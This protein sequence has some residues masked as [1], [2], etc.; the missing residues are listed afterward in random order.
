MV[1]GMHVAAI[2]LSGCS[3]ASDASDTSVNT[4]TVPRPGSAKITTFEAPSSVACSGHPS[5]TFSVQYET[6]GA[7]YQQLI[8]DGRA[9][10]P[11]EAPSGAMAAPVHCD[12]LQHT[13][14]L[15]A[16]DGKGRLTSQAKYLATDVMGTG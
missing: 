11:S 6:T 15:A 2:A 4:T 10:P 7:K 8:V 12:A 14:V 9:Y 1:V 3:G 13:V 16:Y 5:V